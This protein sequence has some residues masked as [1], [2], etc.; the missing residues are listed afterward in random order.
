LHLQLH[1]LLSKTEV[2]GDE[3]IIE[4]KNHVIEVFNSFVTYFD[5]NRIHLPS[6]VI[7]EIVLIKTRAGILG[8]IFSAVFEGANTSI[9]SAI[10]TIN[11]GAK[12]VNISAELP[13]VGEGVDPKEALVYQFIDHIN[14]ELKA[15][16]RQLENLYKSVADTKE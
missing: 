2:L 4:K 16:L 7:S 15:L 5:D 8:L 9:E 14:D 10:A 6:A 3:K 1:K 13:K 12:W 11:M